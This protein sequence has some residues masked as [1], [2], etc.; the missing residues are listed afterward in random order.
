MTLVVKI[1]NTQKGGSH[2]AKLV[3]VQPDGSRS[4]PKLLKGGESTDVTLV[5]GSTLKV[6]EVLD[7]PKPRQERTEVVQLGVKGFDA[8]A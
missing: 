5:A 6:V 2:L 1:T 3:N 7:E 4:E 8:S